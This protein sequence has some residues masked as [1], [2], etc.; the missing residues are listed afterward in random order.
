MTVPDEPPVQIALGDEHTCALARSGRMWCWGSNR[1]G[2]LGDGTA[3]DP[4][5]FQQGVQPGTST[6]GTGTRLIREF[7][8]VVEIGAGH[9]HTCAR[10]AG[11]TVWCWGHN[12]YGELGDG[13]KV[14]RASPVAAQ[15]P[16]AAVGLDVGDTHVCARLATGDVWCWGAHWLIGF[17]GDEGVKWSP[18][19]AVL[20]M[21][22]ATDLSVGAAHVC[23]TFSGKVVCWGDNIWGQLGDPEAPCCSEPPVAADV[24]GLAA[25]V[26]LASGSNHTC[27]RTAG[28]QVTCWGGLLGE[29]FAPRED[30]KSTRLNSSHNSE[31]RMPS[32]A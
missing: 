24:F 4:A 3:E 31:S 5:E 13:T 15:I 25:A 2:Q 26:Q 1:Y 12:G 30:R 6:T 7:E 22:G 8:D 17:F 14:H 19:V 11:G 21:T 20:P 16:A 32:S 27:A 10:R 28:G 23:G 18:P 29:E 9:D